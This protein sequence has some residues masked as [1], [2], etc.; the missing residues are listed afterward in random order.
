MPDMLEALNASEVT[1]STTT[2]KT[3]S[4]KAVAAHALVLIVMIGFFAIVAFFVLSVWLEGTNIETNKA[5]CTFKKVQY[6]TDWKVNNYDTAPWVWED[7]P[8][9]GCEVAG[10]EIKKP[11]SAADCRGLV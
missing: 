1:S 7:R 8:P 3:M 11:T 9:K 4:K 10:I 6:C 2:P 5:T